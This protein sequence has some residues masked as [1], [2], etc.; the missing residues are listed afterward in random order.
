MKKK[1]CKPEY[2]RGWMN[3]GFDLR[4]LPIE[5]EL[6]ACRRGDMRG[7]GRPIDR[8][9][10][11]EGEQK[12]G[13]AQCSS[14]HRQPFIEVSSPECHLQ[15]PFQPP[16]THIRQKPAFVSEEKVGSTPLLYRF[17]AI[18]ADERGGFPSSTI[19]KSQASETRGAYLA[20]CCRSAVG[21][22]ISNHHSII[23]R[24]I[25]W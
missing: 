1:N 20:G 4:L 21:G 12:H 3:L 2:N 9:L 7:S 23:A 11:M 16:T 8:C 13:K 10:G 15:K 5:P 22:S 24:I 19:P 17:C 18:D 14:Q 25:G 6:C